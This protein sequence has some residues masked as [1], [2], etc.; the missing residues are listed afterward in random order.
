MSIVV[1][2][3]Y[4]RIVRKEA[5]PS[6]E[7]IVSLFES[8]TD[9]LV[10]GFR[11]VA[12]GHKVML[13]TGKSSMITSLSILDGNP[14]DSTLVHG[15]LTEHVAVFGAPPTAAAFDGCF[16]SR[17]NRDHAKEIGVK[18]LTFSKN[19][20]LDLASLMENPKLHKQLRNFRAGIEGC[21]SFLKRI[22]GFSR[23]F[24]RS[25]ETF[26]A[27]LQMGAFSCNLT[28]LVRMRLARK[29]C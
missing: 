22:F 29:T 18:E 28:L 6:S 13:T 3:A 7:K 16:A 25:S 17:E 2:Q 20:T 12:F 1:D 27:A 9:I 5:V 24:D 23:V 21:I 26:K 11:D 4:R 14:K 19:G 8:D 15:A 10:K